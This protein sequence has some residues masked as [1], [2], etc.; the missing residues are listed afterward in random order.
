MSAIEWTCLLCGA[1]AQVNDVSAIK[2]ID[3]THT[4][5]KKTA[6]LLAELDE[7]RTANTAMQELIVTRAKERDDA[8]FNANQ[9]AAEVERLT[10]QRDRVREVLTNARNTPGHLAAAIGRIAAIVDDGAVTR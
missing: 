2:V 4:C 9:R 7:Y 3:E 10:A 8:V 6:Q 1:T 5:A